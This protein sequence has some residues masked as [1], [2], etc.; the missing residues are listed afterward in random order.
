MTGTREKTDM[1][2]IPQALLNEL[3]RGDVHKDIF[4]AMALLGITSNPAA[5]N[6]TEAE[7]SAFARFAYGIADA[8]MSERSIR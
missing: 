4:A 1:S 8:M 2:E 3:M 7:Y 5:Y 6:L